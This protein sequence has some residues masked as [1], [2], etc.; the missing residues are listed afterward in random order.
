MGIL[1]LDEDPVR[2]IKILEENERMGWSLSLGFRRWSCGSSSL[3][4]ISV[5]GKLRDASELAISLET[6]FSVYQRGC[7]FRKFSDVADDWRKEKDKRFSWRNGE[8]VGDEAV[9]EGRWR[10]RSGKRSAENN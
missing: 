5:R 8:N 3:P 9:R 1:R 4:N 10:D 6:P 7:D 2:A